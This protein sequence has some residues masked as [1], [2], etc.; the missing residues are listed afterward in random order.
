MLVL[1]LLVLVLI[2]V[3]SLRLEAIILDC[4]GGWI[5]VWGLHEQGC[6]C[7][8][9]MLRL[10]RDGRL[11]SWKMGRELL[12]YMLLVAQDAFEFV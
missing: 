9:S 4:R 8:R 3:V 1:V 10:R 6:L 12:E 5:H 11:R 2:H 7:L